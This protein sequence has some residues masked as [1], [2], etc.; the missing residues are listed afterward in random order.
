M[1]QAIA[2]KLQYKAGD[3]TYYC[4]ELPATLEAV[5]LGEQCKT[6]LPKSKNEQVDFV[7]LFASNSK[8]L[9]HWWPK[10]WPLLT[11]D[12]RCW[13]AY[14]KMSSGV[15]SDLTRD[16][17]WMILT[18]AG[19]EGVRMVALDSTWSAARFKPAA[20]IPNRTRGFSKVAPVEIPGVDFEKRTVMPPPDLQVL[21]DKHKTACSFFQALS[22]TN[23][24]E[25]V[26]W[27]TGAKKEETR[28]KRV[29]AAL[30]KLKAG[31]K[32][33]SEK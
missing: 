31:K 12:A 29:K 5:F 32:N 4:L 18:A 25:Y 7:L 19:W 1:E 8:V 15:E 10:I 6:A 11:P 14:P 13:I 30:D 24:K 16:E 21:L 28:I 27:I 22:F 9:Q 20:N 3:S 2:K 33:P 26:V 23:K 17:G